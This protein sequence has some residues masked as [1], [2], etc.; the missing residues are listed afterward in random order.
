MRNIVVALDGSDPSQLALDWVQAIAPSPA[1]AA[2]HLVHGFSPFY[3]IGDMSA[4]AYAVDLERAE[5]DGRS[6]LEDA[7]AMLSGFKVAK[8]LVQ[9]P[10]AVAILEVARKCS[11]DLIAVG[12]RGGNPVTRLLLGSVS[13][14]VVHQAHAAVLVA[15]EGE[16]RTVRRVLVGVDG[17]AHSARALEFADLWFPEA[18]ITALHVAPTAAEAE[19]TAGEVVARTLELAGV[20]PER[21]T[22]LGAAGGA[23]EGLV[24]AYR[25]G[26]Y[27]MAVVG[28]R[29]M[30]T[31]GELFLG[32]V[33]ERLLRLGPGPV[34]VVK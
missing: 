14:D 29:G 6:L 4:S 20:V 9:E 24:N 16:A 3:P 5:E 2:L 23:A 34:I 33:S 31:L 15:H 25:S 32:S 13:A 10:P 21:V 11:A 28:S 17:S 22:P 7:A 12:R 26:H 19:A 27:D 30:G 1:K 18:E 8:Y